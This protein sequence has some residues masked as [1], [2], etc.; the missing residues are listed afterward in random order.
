MKNVVILISGRGSNMQAIVNA[1]IPNAHICAVLSNSENAA[2]LAW[3]A[4]RGI[5]T[6]ALNHQAFANRLAFDTAMMAL[7]DTYQPDLVIIGSAIT[8]AT[9]PRKVTKQI[10][11]IMGKKK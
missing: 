3:A 9:E 10:Y 1:S 4:E 8:N 6:G 11:E 7:I 2:G 5:A